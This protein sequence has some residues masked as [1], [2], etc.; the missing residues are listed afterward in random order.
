MTVPLIRSLCLALAAG[1]SVWAYAAKAA[2]P[3][4]FIVSYHNL[5]YAKVAC[6]HVFEFE[7]DARK[8]MRNAQRFKWQLSDDDTYKN[9]LAGA[10]ECRSVRDPRELGRKLENELI[11][12]L[13]VNTR[14]GGVTVMRDPHPDYD[15]GSDTD[16]VR[17]VG[18]QSFHW[19]LHIDYNPGSKTYGWT[20]FPTDPGPKMAGPFVSGEGDTAKNADQICVVVTKKGAVIR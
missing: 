9:V 18:Q 1:A 19:D 13:A 17:K 7:P 6:E 10:A 2:E 8:A 15:R 5:D 14:C 16:E 20:L 4:V 3:I 12:A 11:D